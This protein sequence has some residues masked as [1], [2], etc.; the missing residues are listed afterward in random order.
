MLSLLDLRAV[1]SDLHLHGSTACAKVE[2][3]ATMVVVTA[4]SPSAT[5]F[6][7][8][9]RSEARLFREFTSRGLR[10][11]LRPFECGCHVTRPCDIRVITR[12][13]FASLE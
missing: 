2:Q 3:Y 7:R 6:L 12:R 10:S 4:F 11:G 13:V 1:P 5:E 8:A 9:G